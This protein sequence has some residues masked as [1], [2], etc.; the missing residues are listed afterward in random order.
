MESPKASKDSLNLPAI[1]LGTY[2]LKGED[3]SPII[4]EAYLLGY[5]HFDTASFYQNEKEVGEALKG[6][7]RED[8][9]L[10]S[11]VWHDYMGYH[12]V[13]ESFDR[14]LND[15][16]VDQVDLFLIH[17]PHP[18]DLIMESL[19]ALCDLQKKGRLLH[20]GV[21]NFTIRHLQEAIDAGFNIAC[22]QV[23]YHPY[24]NQEE[25]L[26]FCQSNNIQL[27]SYCPIARGAV[28]KDKLML[29]LGDKYNKTPVQITLR[30]HIQKGII[31]LP[32]TKNL[33]RL[34]ENFDVFDFNLSDEE[35]VKINHLNKNERI[36]DREWSHFDY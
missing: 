4:K 27:I 29:E 6:I 10:T 23:E 35:I 2:L 1:A 12:R 36:V 24:L 33:D 28:L 30:W 19:E 31:P 32:K 11:K 26:S 22:N 13:L 5:R 20:Y 16:Q 9:K 18:H 8:Y 15:L 3:V 17:W 14:S 34:S 21:S 7:P 25:L